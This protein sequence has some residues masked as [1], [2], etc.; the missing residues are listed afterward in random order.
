M[1]TLERAQGLLQCELDNV[2][3]DGHEIIV[4]FGIVEDGH[5]QRGLTISTVDGWFRVEGSDSARTRTFLSLANAYKRASDFIAAT[6][7]VPA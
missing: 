5:R 7:L 3:Q 1:L 4:N 6:G 2:Y